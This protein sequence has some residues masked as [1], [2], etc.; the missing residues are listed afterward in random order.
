MQ[1]KN[2]KLPTGLITAITLLAAGASAHSADIGVA[3]PLMPLV[4]NWTGFYL[5]GNLGG[6]FAQERA[7]TPLGPWSP[8]PS[9][10]FGGAQVGYNFMVTPSWLIG[11]EGEFSATSA[12]GTV[13]IP[14]MIAAATITSNHR[15]YDTVTGRLGFVQ[16]PWLVYAKGGAAWIDVDYRMTGTFNGVTS[17]ATATNTATGWTLGTGVEYM[18]APHWSVKAEYDYLDFGTQNVAFGALGT[19]LAVTTQVHEFKVGVNWH[20][21]Q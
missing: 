20:W 19:S 11:V 7:V 15:S 6:A 21:L 16:G 1:H 14:N 4:P 2:R 10:I 3:P 17:M 13:V 9:G 12:Q 18:W 8:N 5:G